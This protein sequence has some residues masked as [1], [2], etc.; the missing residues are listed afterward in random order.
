MQIVAHCNAVP[1][2]SASK[3]PLQHLHYKFCTMKKYMCP[4]LPPFKMWLI[5]KFDL[6]EADM[7]NKKRHAVYYSCQEAIVNY[8]H[9][10]VACYCS[11]GDPVFECDTS[12]WT[13][14]EN[15]L[16][17]CNHSDHRHYSNPGI[18]LC[19]EYQTNYTCPY[20]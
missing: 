8:L 15:T 17:H 12:L 16:V 10:Q 1:C 6:A 3:W 20:F 7:F 11:L 13:F 18:R 5:S 14:C 9:K 19:V 4:A 2:V